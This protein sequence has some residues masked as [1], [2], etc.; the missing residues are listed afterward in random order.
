MSRH[1]IG[2]I[3]KLCSLNVRHWVELSANAGVDFGWK[4]G[5]DV[6]LFA[7]QPGR[8]LVQRST[9]SRL[10]LPSLR[11]KSIVMGQP[12]VVRIQRK[13]CLTSILSR[14]NSLTEGDLTKETRQKTHW[15][16]L[17]DSIRF[18]CESMKEMRMTDRNEMEKQVVKE[19]NAINGKWNWN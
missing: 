11:V 17:I 13:P 2:W 3:I 15:K 5:H 16:Y 6:P 8:K 7:D 14:E 12:C 19:R 9:G 1:S 10:L 4:R 18:E